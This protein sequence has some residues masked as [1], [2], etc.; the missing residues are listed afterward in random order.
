MCVCITQSQNK[1]F[2]FLK[3]NDV[4]LFA[5]FLQCPIEIRTYEIQ[6]FKYIYVGYKI[7]YKSI[8]CKLL[9]T[10]FMVLLFLF[11]LHL[12]KYS[13]RNVNMSHY[14]YIFFLFPYIS[15]HFCLMYLCSLLL[16]VWWFIMSIFFVNCT[17]YH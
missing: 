6:H 13:Q 10:S 9:M 16:S 7:K 14:V 1:E 15:S 17:F 5:S 2:Y 12:I 8:I 3:F 11:F 4:Y